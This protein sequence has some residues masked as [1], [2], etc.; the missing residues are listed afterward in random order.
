[1]EFKEKTVEAATE[2]G[3][4]EMGLTADQAI[5]TVIDQG[6]FLKRPASTLKKS[7]PAQMRRWPSC[8]SWP[9]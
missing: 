9:T 1:M 4:K 2:L 6:G 8:A 7:P 5:V 3:L